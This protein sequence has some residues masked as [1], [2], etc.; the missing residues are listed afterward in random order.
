MKDIA[1]TQH[2]TTNYDTILK[3]I[4]FFPDTAIDP[5][6]GDCDLL[7]YSPHTSWSFYDI[8]PKS[9]KVIYN[10]SLMNPPDYNDK[11]VITNPPYLAKNKTKEFSDIF[12][13]YHTDDL[14]KAAIISLVR[15]NCK[16]GILIIPVNFFTDEFTND[17]RCMFL[18]RY[19]ISYVNY[20]E[21]QIFSNTTY[22]ICAFYFEKYTGGTN[23]NVQF[24]E[25]IQ[26]SSIDISI[27]PEYGYRVGGEF[28]AC[29][30]TIKPEFN[31]AVKN[32]SYN[33]ITRLYLE[34][35]DTRTKHLHLEL[36]DSPYY[37]INSDRMRATLT[38]NKELSHDDELYIANTFNMY[39]DD[40]RKKYGNLILTN[41]RDFGRKRISF[42]DVYKICTMI[43]QNRENK[44]NNV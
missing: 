30:K 23:G 38:C 25:P 16:N 42:E 40:E 3:N 35:L 41:F 7:K 22:N 39:M 10:D 2:F 33:F 18:S 43:I 37:G 26:N 15:G 24:Y 20:F 27:K 6:A 44:T 13:K 36:H 14:Y 4:K 28:Y 29:L 1:K 9:S 19:K 34:A 5:F 11:S 21:E 12:K 31:R 17:I 8:D 32:V